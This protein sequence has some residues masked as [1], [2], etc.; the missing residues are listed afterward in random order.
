MD[1]K[2]TSNSI[3]ESGGTTSL[4]ELLEGPLH[5]DHSLNSVS[6]FDVESTALSDIELENVLDTDVSVFTTELLLN[7]SVH[8]W[9]SSFVP[10]VHVENYVVLQNL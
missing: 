3:H 1:T 9:I 7:S 8:W 10:L 5:S 2:G 6:R 4:E